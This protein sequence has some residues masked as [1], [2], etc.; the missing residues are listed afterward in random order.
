[1]YLQ[2]LSG[3]ALSNDL[4]SPL[5]LDMLQ[6]HTGEREPDRLISET[7]RILPL[8][9]KLP[10][11]HHVVQVARKMDIALSLWTATVPFRG[12]IPVKE[13]RPRD[14]RMKLHT[15][16]YWLSVPPAPPLKIPLGWR[17]PSKSW[18]LF[19]TLPIPLKAFTVWWR[20]LHGFLPTKSRLHSLSPSTFLS[21]LCPHCQT[22]EEDDF[23]FFVGCPQ[24]E[25]IWLNNWHWH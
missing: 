22:T 8:T 12:M 14:F 4:T 18:T 7:V 16:S 21:P 13:V 10:A 9:K 15:Q 23:H 24:K 2:R 3:P 6:Y 25:A 5:L 19:W 20:L 17:L 11:L 1:M